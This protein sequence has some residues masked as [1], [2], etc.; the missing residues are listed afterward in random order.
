MTAYSF[1]Y[2]VDEGRPCEHNKYQPRKRQ[3]KNLALLSGTVTLSDGT[4]EFLSDRFGAL[5]A[6][7]RGLDFVAEMR[8]LLATHYPTLRSG[9]PTIGASGREL[10]RE[11]SR[12]LV[13]GRNRRGIAKALW[14]YG[15]N[16]PR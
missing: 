12:P 5:C 15:M 11:A 3:C 10:L 7:H 2:P 6:H 16:R 14:V 1:Q 9:R 8:E 4:T 13:M